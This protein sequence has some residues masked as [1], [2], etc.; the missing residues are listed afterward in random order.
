TTRPTMVSAFGLRWSARS[1]GTSSRAR[2]LT[3]AWNLAVN[4][5]CDLLRAR[6]ALCFTVDVEHA[7]DHA[8]PVV[9]LRLVHAVLTHPP[10]RRC[11]VEQRAERSRPRMR[12]PRRQQQAVLTRRRPPAVVLGGERGD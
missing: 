5:G 10:S 2:A 7:V 4:T 8:A 9:L 11:I 3:Q 1:A 6:A 12:D